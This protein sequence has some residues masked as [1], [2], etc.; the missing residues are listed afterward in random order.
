MPPTEFPRRWVT[1]IRY[2][3]FPPVPHFVRRPRLTSRE[4]PLHLVDRHSSASDLITAAEPSPSS[5]TTR[6]LRTNG[7][8]AASFTSRN[9][10][11]RGWCQVD[12]GF[13]WETGVEPATSSLGI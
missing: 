3:T 1:R 4:R 13:K 10:T 11:G 12:S 2:G 5:A 8:P 6:Y 9:D 7:F